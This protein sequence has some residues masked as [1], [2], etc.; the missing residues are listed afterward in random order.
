MEGGH[1]T[2]VPGEGPGPLPGEENYLWHNN[3]SI[4]LCDTL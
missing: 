2:G 3:K 1:V 4:I